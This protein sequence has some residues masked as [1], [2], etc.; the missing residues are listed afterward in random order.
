MDAGVTDK[1]SEAELRDLSLHLQSVRE[2]ERTRIARELHDDLGSIL[3]AIKLDAQR[4]VG[5]T[6]ADPNAH[7]AFKLQM[8]DQALQ[9]VK[10]IIN[11]LR[12]GILDHLGIWA[13]ME[14][15]TK[16]FQQR[17]GIAAQLTLACEEF[18]VDADRSTAIFR[19]YQEILTNIA[20]HAHASQVQ[21]NVALEQQDIMIQVTDNGVGISS[22]ALLNVK[23]FG[24]RGMHERARQFNGTVQILNEAVGGARVIFRIPVKD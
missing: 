4:N 13:A 21:T 11:D 5:Q 8:I 19:I 12:P 24:I 14:W 3:T 1:P 9:S 15:Q 16:E 2:A 10:R 6:E 20:K 17:T 23:S 22:A 7:A 18:A